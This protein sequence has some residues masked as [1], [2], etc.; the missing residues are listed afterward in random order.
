MQG[1]DNK[2][3]AHEQALDHLNNSDRNIPIVLSM[4]DYDALERAYGELARAYSLTGYS[5]H[6][7]IMLMI[8]NTL[9]DMDSPYDKAS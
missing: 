1:N 5:A 8:Q 2:K 4:I 6:E 3:S 9:D 7:E